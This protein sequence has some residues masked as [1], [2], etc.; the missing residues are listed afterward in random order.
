VGEDFYASDHMATV[1]RSPYT[2]EVFGII[3]VG[4]NVTNELLI[5]FFC[6]CQILEKK[7]EFNEIV[8]HLQVYVDFNDSVRRKV[9]HN[10]VTI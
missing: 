7:L 2:D 10:I 8:H 5:R 1:I 4:L 3:R 6:I 9:L